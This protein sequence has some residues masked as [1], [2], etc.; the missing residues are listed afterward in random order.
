MS[1]TVMP[2]SRVDWHRLVG[3]VVMTLEPSSRYFLVSLLKN[4][5][6]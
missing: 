5:G 6:M 1:V 2:S 4:Q 3:K